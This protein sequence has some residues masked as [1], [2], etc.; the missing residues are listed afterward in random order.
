MLGKQK[1]FLNSQS[2]AM[3]LVFSLVSFP[4]GCEATY[5]CCMAYNNN[6]FLPT[7]QILEREVNKK[8]PSTFR[9]TIFFLR[10]TLKNSLSKWSFSFHQKQYILI[11]LMWK[12]SILE[13]KNKIVEEKL[14]TSRQNLKIFFSKKKVYSK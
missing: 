9:K 13:V 8:T 4:C 6:L 10:S 5:S 11:K 3:L 1:L 7:W 12:N 2:S 14:I